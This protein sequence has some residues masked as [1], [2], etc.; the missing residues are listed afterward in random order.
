MICLTTAADSNAVVG[1][2]LVVE[3]A[4]G[5]PAV[6]VVVHS[7]LDIHMDLLDRLSHSLRSQ[8][9]LGTR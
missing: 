9:T 7:A 3:V 2:R 1:S 8:E 5:M 4:V 6:V